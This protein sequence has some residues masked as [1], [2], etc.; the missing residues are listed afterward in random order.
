M[1]IHTLNPSISIH[2]RRLARTPAAR[3]CVSVLAGLI[4]LPAGSAPA[5]TVSQNLE[6]L[7]MPAPHE[8]P[9][10]TREPNSREQRSVPRQQLPGT[11]SGRQGR[12]G[13]ATRR[14]DAGRVAPPRI[15]RRMA[16]PPP[17]AKDRGPPGMMGLPWPKTPDE[18]EKTIS[19]L[20]AHLATEA[21]GFRAGEIA[22]EIEKLRRLPAGDTVN[23]LI[24]RAQA[25]TAKND[26]DTAL[27][28]LDAASS[29]APDV[30]EV[31]NR[32][33]YVYYRKENL[34]AALADLKRTLAIEPTHFRA[35]D[36]MAK[37]LEANGEKA[38]ALKAYD[39]LLMVYPE[40][41]GADAAAAK[42]REEVQ[43]KGI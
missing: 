21:D 16:A 8:R 23:L 25:L 26:L 35:L 28:I 38:A 11:D 27:Q 43:G 37:I 34:G 9:G 22:T 36:G 6:R 42:L 41:E 15:E 2:C 7:P 31:W 13:S 18:A 40:F 20:L 14:D 24:D 10:S 19:D 30:A 33:A 17:P 5:Q 29:L 39:A 3:L 12:E 32:R 1:I 4:A